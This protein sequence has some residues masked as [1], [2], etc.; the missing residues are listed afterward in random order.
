MSINDKIIVNKDSLE[1]IEI[2]LR[3][4]KVMV[5]DKEIQSLVSD[6]LELLNGEL[7]SIDISLEDII[8]NKMKETK[9]SNPDLHFKLYM[10]YRKLSDGKMDEDEA[11]KAYKAYISI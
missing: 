5:Q 8:Y 6:I 2:K 11:L 7:K 3:G 1:K 10:L 9:H 4:L